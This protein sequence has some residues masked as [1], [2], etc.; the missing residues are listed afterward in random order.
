MHLHGM[1]VCT[2]VHPGSYADYTAS[3]EEWL[4]KAPYGILLNILGGVPLVA[5][6]AFQVLQ[7]HTSVSSL[8]SLAAPSGRAVHWSKPKATSMLPVRKTAAG[9]QDDALSLA[10]DLTSSAINTACR[11]C[12]DKGLHSRQVIVDSCVMDCR[13]WSLAT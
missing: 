2:H 11:T 9:I 1:I 5:L 6:T 4:A 12:C 3:K 8:K 7:G 13:P 10:K